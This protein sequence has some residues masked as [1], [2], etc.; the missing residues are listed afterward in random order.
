MRDLIA[1]KFDADVVVLEGGMGVFDIAVDG[2][3]VFSKHTDGRF[4]EAADIKALGLPEE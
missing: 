1:E 3:I 2:Q 4:P